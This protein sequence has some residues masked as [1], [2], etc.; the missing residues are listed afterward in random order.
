MREMGLM[1]SVAGRCVWMKVLGCD[2]AVD[3]DVKRNETASPSDDMS[4]D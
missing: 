2:R 4:L 3:E 1:M